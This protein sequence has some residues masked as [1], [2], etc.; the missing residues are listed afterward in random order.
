[1]IRKARPLLSAGGQRFLEQ[2]V[3]AIQQFEDLSHVTMGNYVSDPRQ[4]IGRCGCCWNDGLED[5]CFAL[6]VVPL[7]LLIRYREHL[8][9]TPGL[10]SSIV[11][12][13]LLSS[14]QYLGT[15]SPEC[16][17]LFSEDIST[18]FYEAGKQAGS[19]NRE[20]SVTDTTSRFTWLRE[21]NERH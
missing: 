13:K 3:E 12:R 16:S 2:Y 20:A 15:L 4:F 18:S 17:S 5:R 8:Q 11:D 21:P 19:R 9:T 14:N 6:H 1:M 7:S 10:K